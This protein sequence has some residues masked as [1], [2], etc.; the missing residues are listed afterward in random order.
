[1]MEKNDKCMHLLYEKCMGNNL[2]LVQIFFYR[3]SGEEKVQLMQFLDF[4][5]KLS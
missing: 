5:P 2:D 3:K 4:N 1:M